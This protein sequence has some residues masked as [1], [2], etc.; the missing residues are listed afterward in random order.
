MNL[1][2]KEQR[3]QG[4]ASA[5]ALSDYHLQFIAITN[6]LIKKARLSKLEQ[7]RAYIR[8]FQ[9]HFLSAITH[10]LELKNPDHEH[11]DTPFSVE[12]V[13]EAARFLLQ[14]A[15]SSGRPITVPSSP[16]S[17]SLAVPS[18][19]AIA[20]EKFIP[21]MTDFA[22]TIVDAVKS[23]RTQDLLPRKNIVAT[24][25]TRPRFNHVPFWYVAPQATAPTTKQQTIPNF[26][27]PTH[28]VQVIT[29][30]DPIIATENPQV[31]PSQRAVHISISQPTT[32]ENT[33]GHTQSDTTHSPSINKK[34]TIPD[35]IPVIK[36]SSQQLLN[37]QITN[38][39]DS[40]SPSP[41]TDA[42]AIQL[43]TTAILLSNIAATQSRPTHLASNQF[44]P[45]NITDSN[46]PSPSTI[47]TSRSNTAVDHA[48]NGI[49]AFSVIAI[50][51][52]PIPRKVKNII[53]KITEK[54]KIIQAINGKILRPPYDPRTHP[55]WVKRRPFPVP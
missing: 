29:L 44:L 33:N 30:S 50:K 49:N 42:L 43:P 6:W 47:K 52:Q 34:I 36:Q 26:H 54:F 25:V 3:S 9:P 53:G 32:T 17:P 22:K 18:N 46:S 37:S 41:S 13:F 15:A 7:Q 12:K 21:F 55:V 51:Y 19:G 10:R 40:Y 8:A 45:A 38:E 4:I 16:S 24:K 23:S 31:T 48:T 27:Q 28:A 11:P 14:K 5:Q 35:K 1:L 39:T 2:I 20:V